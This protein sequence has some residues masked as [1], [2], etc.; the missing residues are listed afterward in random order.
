MNRIILLFVALCL[1]SCKSHK[2]ITAID[3]NSSISYTDTTRTTSDT[4]SRKSEVVDTTKT[5]A[6]FENRG[7]IEFVDGGGTVRIDTAGN[8]TFEGV[9]NFKGKH[10]GVVTRNNGIGNKVE[11]TAI[12]HEQ[13]NGVEVQHDEQI[14]RTEEKEP[15]TKWHET[16]FARIGQGVFISALLW[17]MF[18]YLRR[19]H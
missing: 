17:M 18:L 3:S 6:N 9:K 5:E 14:K 7:F 1:F 11:E 16:M 12:H 2:T 8:V 15:K 10:A 19:K 13:I 4:L